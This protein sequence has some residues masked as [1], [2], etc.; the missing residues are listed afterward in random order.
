MNGMGGN[1]NNMMMNPMMMSMMQNMMGM[2][3]QPNSAAAQGEAKGDQA[4]P[5][6]LEQQLNMM[7]YTCMMQQ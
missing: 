2:S 3:F 1:M 7:R 4:A 6:N 5:T